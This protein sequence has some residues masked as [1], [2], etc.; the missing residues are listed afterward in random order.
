MKK[1]RPHAQPAFLG[2]KP[3]VVK[4]KPVPLLKRVFNWLKRTFYKIQSALYDSY[5]VFVSPTYQK[6]RPFTTENKV[7]AHEIGHLLMAKAVGIS[8]CSH[9]WVDLEG[10]EHKLNKRTYHRVGETGIAP[11]AIEREI[12][13]DKLVGSAKAF[14]SIYAGDAL[15]YKYIVKESAKG[16]HQYF[17]RLEKL[18]DLDRLSGIDV[19]TTDVGFINTVL[20]TLN[21]GASKAQIYQKA[22]EVVTALHH[23]V[24]EDK[25]HELVSELLTQKRIDGADNVNT[26]LK[27]HIGTPNWQHVQ[28]EFDEFVQLLKTPKLS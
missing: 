2:L 12:Q 26:F 1:T 8:E 13:K 5:L 11:E 27:K 16:F 15:A 4:P 6:M 17:N 14:L 20:K 24:G 22:F 23:T 3:H 21:S 10:N 28:R 18:H 25:T 9:I 7:A 19:S